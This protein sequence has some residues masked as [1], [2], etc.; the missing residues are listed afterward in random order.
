MTGIVAVLQ[1]DGQTGTVAQLHNRRRND[2]DAKTVFQRTHH[3]AGQF[4]SNGSRIAARSLTLAPVFKHGKTHSHILTAARKAETRNS[5]NI[6]NF[7]NV[8]R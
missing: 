6:F 2:G 8:F 7:R 3:H 1:V 4:A 5:N